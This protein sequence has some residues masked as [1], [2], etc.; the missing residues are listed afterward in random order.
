M[1]TPVKQFDIPYRNPM[2][3]KN[4][5]MTEP[6]QWF[7]MAVWERLYSLGFERQFSIVN[8][9]SSPA[10]IDGM[11]FDKRGVT[12]AFVDFMIQRVTTGTGASELIESGFFICTYRP[13]SEDWDI[14]LVD[15]DN[16]DDSGVD[17]IITSE[18]Q[19]QYTSSDIEAT[20]DPSISNLFWRARTIGGKNSQYSI[21]GAR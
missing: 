5:M 10:D 20:A 21:A 18:G 11:K 1:S 12:Q 15:I 9:Q 4:G 8:D 17:F 3:D 13:S 7:F 2:V 16:P 14:N 6:W 19:V